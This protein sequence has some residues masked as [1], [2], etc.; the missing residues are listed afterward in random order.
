MTRK[1]QI[2]LLSHHRK[3]MDE[4][5]TYYRLL[6]RVLGVG[7]FGKVVAAESALDPNI[8]FSVKIVSKELIGEGMDH[9]REVYS[10][11]KNIKHESIL[12]YKLYENDSYMYLV[13]EY[14]HGKQ[15]LDLIISSSNDN[16][17]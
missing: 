17:G 16:K 9:F 4:F 12:T 6:D 15:L 14:F 5:K 10:I 13:M 2:A 8:K 7:S 3:S 11:L 1:S